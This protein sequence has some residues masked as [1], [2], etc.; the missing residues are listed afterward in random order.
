MTY[1]SVPPHYENDRTIDSIEFV[2]VYRVY[3]IVTLLPIFASSPMYDRMGQYIKRGNSTCT[4]RKEQKERKSKTIIIFFFS[5]I[6][7]LT[8][9]RRIETI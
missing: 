4:I 9:K 1:F 2:T 8:K 6:G 5:L 3:R 7:T